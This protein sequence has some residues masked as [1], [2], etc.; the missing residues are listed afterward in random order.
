MLTCTLDPPADYPC[1]PGTEVILYENGTVTPEG[2]DP[3]EFENLSE[4]FQN[5]TECCLNTKI[6]WLAKKFAG[7]NQPV[8]TEIQYLI[9]AKTPS[10]RSEKSTIHKKRSVYYPYSDP[11]SREHDLTNVLKYRVACK[12]GEHFSNQLGKCVPGDYVVLPASL[13]N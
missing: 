3:Y 2:M 7:N 11:Y 6:T 1:I 10:K 4:M 5:E 13:S 8:V 9:T 12:P